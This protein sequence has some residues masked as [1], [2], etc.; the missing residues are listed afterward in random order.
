[1]LSSKSDRLKQIQEQ[2]EAACKA[3]GRAPASVALL[4]V[5]KTKSWEEVRDFRLLGLSEFGENYV[6]EGVAKSAAL[7]AWEKANPQATKVNWHFIGSLQ[8]NKAKFIPGTFSLF[9]ALDSLSL[10][11]KLSRAAE[12][13]GIVQDCLVEINLDHEASKG[14]LHPEVLPKFLEELNPLPALNV[15]GLMCIPAPLPERNQREPFARLRELKD[16][17]NRAGAYRSQLSELS[18]GMS[19]DFSEAILEGST[20]IRVGTSLFGARS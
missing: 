10:A 1:M 4:A 5:S 20:I 19:G 8:S 3:A 2:I 7:A 13:K 11:A 9:H 18:M 12:S 15:K 14:G 16:A 6:Q 17:L